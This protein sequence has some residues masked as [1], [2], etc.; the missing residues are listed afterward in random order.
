MGNK[1]KE[2]VKSK[3]KQES[4]QTKKNP[5]QNILEI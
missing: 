2:N 5:V 1:L 4:K 3:N